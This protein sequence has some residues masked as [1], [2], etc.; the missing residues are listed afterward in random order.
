MYKVLVAEDEDVLRKG[1]I[2]SVPWEEL[3]CMVVAEA[4]NGEE[5][6]RLIEEKMPDIVLT[7][8]NMPVMDGLEMIRRTKGRNDFATIIL[9]GYSDFVYAQE[10][11]RYGVTGYILKPY[12]LIELKETLLRAIEQCRE[13]QKLLERQD[14]KES[15]RSI[16]ML[17]NLGADQSKGMVGDVLAYIHRNYQDKI[18]MQDI[19]KQVNYSERTINLRFK[20]TVGTTVIDYLNRYRIQCAIE[21]LKKGEKSV[22]EI[23][24]QCG[25]GDYKYF[26]LVFKKYIGC[27]PKEYIM[28]IF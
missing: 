16:S 11:I 13:K 21:E 5:G 15:W 14:A 1:I 6:I 17:K 28:Y 3:G 22:N 4:R 27:S 18:T 2:F 20:E 12:Q 23:A 25:F 7:D 24:G 19:E 8:I 10:A 9:S 26:G